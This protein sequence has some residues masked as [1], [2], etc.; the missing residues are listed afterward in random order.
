[1]PNSF[2][3]SSSIP[4]KPYLDMFGFYRKETWKIRLNLLENQSDTKKN[5][6]RSVPIGPSSFYSY[7]GFFHRICIKYTF[8]VSYQDYWAQVFLSLFILSFNK[9]IFI[10]MRQ[11]D[12]NRLPLQANIAFFHGLLKFGCK[13]DTIKLWQKCHL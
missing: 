2:V 9:F 3:S 13:L 10:L 12:E 4:V 1:M 7:F 8:V 6:N 5:P 11:F